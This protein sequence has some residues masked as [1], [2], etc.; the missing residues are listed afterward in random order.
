MSSQTYR[1]KGMRSEKQLDCNVR[2]RSKEGKVRPDRKGIL[3]PFISREKRKRSSEDRHFT[4][5]ERIGD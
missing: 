2:E 5:L 4:K 3:I 1:K